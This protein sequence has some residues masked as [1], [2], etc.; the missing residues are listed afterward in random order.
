MSDTQPN[1]ELRQPLYIVLTRVRIKNCV[2]TFVMKI[3]V[4]CREECITVVRR[5]FLHSWLALEINRNAIKEI[6]KSKC[7]FNS[8]RS[9]GAIGRVVVRY[10]KC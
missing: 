2:R 6:L 3:N 1:I 8:R 9:G 5:V 4:H 10:I 7:D